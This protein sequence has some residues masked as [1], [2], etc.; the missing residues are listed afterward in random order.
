[1]EIFETINCFVFD[2]KHSYTQKSIING[3]IA[4]GII[5]LFSFS[6]SVLGFL[7]RHILRPLIPW[8]HIVRNYGGKKQ[9]ALVTGGTDG[10]GLEI[11]N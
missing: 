3:V 9:W 1:M 2:P 4:L 5:Q 7:N 10:I 6:L 11:C 8:N